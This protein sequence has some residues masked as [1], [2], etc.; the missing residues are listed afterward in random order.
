MTIRRVT[1]PAAP[2]PPPERWSNCLVCDGIAYVSGMVARGNDVK[3]LAGKDE[4]EQ[5]KIIFTK[6]KGLIEAAGGAMADV[7]KIIVYVTNIK[8]NTKVWKAR[9][10][11]FKGNFPASTLVQVAALASPEILVEIEAIAHIGKGP[12]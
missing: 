1:S 2:E 11:F 3:E 12:R 8:N 7:V 10:E 6:I 4:Y 5:A 9:A